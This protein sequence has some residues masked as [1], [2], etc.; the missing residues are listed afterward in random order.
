VEEVEKVVDD[1]KYWTTKT[2]FIRE[3][4]NAKLIGYK[5]KFEAKERD[6]RE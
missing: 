3:A 5:M 2:D 1:L 4:V 6:E